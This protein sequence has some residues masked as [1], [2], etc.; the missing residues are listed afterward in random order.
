MSYIN[1]INYLP[2]L[3][4]VDNAIYQLKNILET[5]IQIIFTFQQMC[6]FEVRS[7]ELFLT[8]VLFSNTL[9]YL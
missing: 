5:N 4:G 3:K 1:I 2:P 7:G 6:F 9:K 8:F